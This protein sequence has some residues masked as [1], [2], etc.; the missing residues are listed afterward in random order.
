MI[1]QWV[2]GVNNNDQFFFLFHTT[3]N[4]FLLII[5]PLPLSQRNN[6]Y[7]VVYIP[8]V[9]RQ[10]QVCKLLGHQDVALGTEPRRNDSPR[11]R[12]VPGL[13]AR[14]AKPWCYN[15]LCD[16]RTSLSCLGLHFLTCKVREW[17]WMV[18]RVISYKRFS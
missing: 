11:L 13:S 10:K 1:L 8:I 16:L 18:S 14:K 12:K 2:R 9:L 3:Q 5:T 17:D 6:H 4:L 7:G 15:Q